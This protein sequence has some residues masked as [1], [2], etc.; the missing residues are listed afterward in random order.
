LGAVKRARQRALTHSAGAEKL[1]DLGTGRCTEATTE[2][3]ALQRGRS[4][5][6]SCGID[7]GVAFANRERKCAVKNVAGGERVDHVNLWRGSI[8]PP[9]S[10]HALASTLIGT[11]GISGTL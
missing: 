4:V 10:M 1:V 11:V 3:R 6:E 5:G 7:D 2:A 8:P 9:D